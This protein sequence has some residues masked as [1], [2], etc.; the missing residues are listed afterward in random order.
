[1]APT[2]H[3]S[4]ATKAQAQSLLAKGTGDAAVQAVALL[5]QDTSAGNN[6]SNAAGVDAGSLL[7]QG[8]TNVTRRPHEA[9]GLAPTASEG[10]VRRAFRKQALRYHPDKTQGTTTQLFQSLQTASQKAL[11]PKHVPPPPPNRSASSSYTGQSGHAANSSS[12]S[13]AASTASAS[14][15]YDR[16][17]R[18]HQGSNYFRGN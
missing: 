5:L 12:S 15:K 10:E 4:A 18:R 11:D 16:F 14:G 2:L 1:M 17:Y 9:L 13:N 6:G 7:Q 3:V 8:L